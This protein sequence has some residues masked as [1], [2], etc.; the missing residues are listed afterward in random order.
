MSATSTPETAS[1]LPWLAGFGPQ[2]LPATLLVEPDTEPGEPVELS[3]TNARGWLP[4]PVVAVESSW[5]SQITVVR[6]GQQQLRLQASL[7]EPVFAGVQGDQCGHRPEMRWP[8]SS[9]LFIIGAVRGPTATF[10]QEALYSR[11]E[12]TRQLTAY[13]M[14]ALPAT[15]LD[16]RHQWTEPSVIALPGALQGEPDSN[17]QLMA[18]D[19][20]RRLGIHTVVRATEGGWEVLTLGDAPSR[21]F[22]I[23]ASAACSLTRYDELRCPMQLAPERGEY[24]RM[25]GGPWTSASIDAAAGWRDQRNRLVAA[26]GCDTCEGTRHQ[27]Q[28]KIHSSGGP[29]TIVNS[30]TPTRWLTPD[31]RRLDTKG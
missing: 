28:G 18:L 31:G 12:L 22:D 10:D 3:G 23:V 15:T 19:I 13:G 30:P 25:R 4:R 11:D 5:L 29:I 6:F 20:S 14:Q 16:R 26:I 27:F 24:C 1:L 2:D 21:E 17:W 7:E 8:L 9:E